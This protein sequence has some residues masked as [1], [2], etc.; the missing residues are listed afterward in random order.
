MIVRNAAATLPIALASIQ[1]VADQLVVIDSGSTDDTRAIAQAHGA[2]VVLHPWQQDYAL[3]RN[4]YLKM[5]TCDW[6]LVLD[7][8][9]FIDLE[10]D[11]W[12]QKLRSG[13]HSAQTDH[14]WVPRR[15]L[16]PFSLTHYLTNPSHYPDWQLRLFRP[17]QQCR[18]EG[19]VHEQLRGLS[20]PGAHLSPFGLYHLDLYTTDRA[21]RQAKV[22]RYAAMGTIQ[23]GADY[24][25]L[26]KLADLE[27]TP[28]CWGTLAAT[29]QR[30]LL[31][32]PAPEPLPP[33]ATVAIALVTTEVS[34]L[35]SQIR[36]YR[37]RL[38]WMEGSKFWQLRRL[39]YWGR[40]SPSDGFSDA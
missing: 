33:E 21:S 31:R 38:R 25:Y 28:F 16:P 27:L 8:D 6:V 37:D 36:H 9:E 12:L 26:P 10:A 11:Q 40:R 20:T 35:Q 13:A 14:Y 3:Q 22:Q 4:Q 5:V 17:T 24:L 19:A 30:Y 23:D 29:V 34:A 15:W 18:Y 1:Q 7:S 39:W 32:L 2:A